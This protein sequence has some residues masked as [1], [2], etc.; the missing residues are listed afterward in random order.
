MNDH[1]AGVDLAAYVDGVLAGGKKAE[2]E[3]HFSHCPECLE[4]LA[5]IVDIQ[6]S[7]VNIPGEF[8]RQALG[9][10]QAARKPVLPLRLVFE[11][12]AAFLVVVF[13]G[14]YF[15]GNNRFWQAESSQ[16]EKAAAPAGKPVLQL[17]PQV[18]PTIPTLAGRVE[19][20]DDA[21]AK[22]MPVEKNVMFAPGP[23]LPPEKKLDQAA[24]V[25]DQASVPADEKE[26]REQGQKLEEAAAQP[27]QVEAD[28]MGDARLLRSRS[29]E[30]AAVVGGVESSLAARGKS[31]QPAGKGMT[32]A[33]PTTSLEEYKMGDE[34][35]YRSRPA[36]MT[37]VSGAVQLFLATTGRA[38]AP[39]GIIMAALAPRSLIRIGG[40][41][42][43]GDLRDPEL[44]DGWSWFKKGMILELELDGSGVV[45]T[46]ITV[47]QWERSTVARAEK[48]ARQL[49]FSVSEKKSRRARI[50]ISGS[51]PN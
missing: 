30:P 13:I 20:A 44:L 22:K 7:R 38:A 9:E 43:W 46:V 41:V 49:T 1:I 47:G 23:L 42:A 8:L 15:L 18:N 51:Q 24:A 2:L 36:E 3:S 45:T 40:D 33:T 37:A 10:K 19:P 4:A 27:I 21:K 12:A 6:S 29:A 32:G 50:S 31:A 11:I 17:P 14:Y 34:E 28:K 35:P 16:K 5:E 25:K 48:A 26:N 39:M